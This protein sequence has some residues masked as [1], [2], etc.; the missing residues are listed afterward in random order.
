MNEFEK[1]KREWLKEAIN[2]KHEKEE[3]AKEEKRIV[4]ECK[5]LLNKQR[6]YGA[7]YRKPQKISG[8]IW[9]CPSCGSTDMLFE[10][11]VKHVGT[12]RARWQPLFTIADGAWIFVTYRYWHCKRCGYK[13]AHESYPRW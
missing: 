7:Y 4:T 8:N 6:I 3:N 10:K 13:G 5:S 1:K 2:W 9:K 11:V 12:K